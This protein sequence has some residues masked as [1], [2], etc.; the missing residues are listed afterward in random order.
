MSTRPQSPAIEGGHEPG[1][2]PEPAL[3]LA[4]RHDLSRFRDRRYA[5]SRRGRALAARS[6]PPLTLATKLQLR[7]PPSGTYTPR[8][9]VPVL[10]GGLPEVP[11]RLCEQGEGQALHAKLKRLLAQLHRLLD[12]PLEI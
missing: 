10:G 1:S 9:H 2:R 4:C 12:D 7:R 5:G 8:R 11:P 3:V 6:H